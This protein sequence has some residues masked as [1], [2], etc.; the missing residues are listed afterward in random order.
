[1]GALKKVVN[2]EAKEKVKKEK[3]ALIFLYKYSQKIRS[4]R[5]I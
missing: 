4:K 5:S 1:L 2:G 3:K